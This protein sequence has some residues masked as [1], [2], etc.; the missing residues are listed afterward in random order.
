MSV[1]EELRGWLG[2]IK[3]DPNAKLCLK[4]VCRFGCFEKST[5]YA[6][7]VDG[8]DDLSRCRPGRREGQGHRIARGRQC[9]LCSNIVLK[10][11]KRKSIN[12]IPKGDWGKLQ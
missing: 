8:K 1:R 6:G 5:V 9:T 11:G 10:D 7:D 2:A 3:W 4:D 12:F